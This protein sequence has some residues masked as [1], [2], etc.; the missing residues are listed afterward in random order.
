MQ[1]FA[2]F[3]CTEAVEISAPQGTKGTA[4]HWGAH[5]ETLL[6]EQW[7]FPGLIFRAIERLSSDRNIIFFLSHCPYQRM[8]FTEQYQSLFIGL[9][10]IEALLLRVFS[11]KRN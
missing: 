11:E 4:S 9:C 8:K 7:D 2:V 5:L 6:F 10:E 1:V 3:G